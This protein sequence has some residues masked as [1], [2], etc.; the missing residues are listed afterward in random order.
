[1]ISSY[2]CTLLSL[3]LRINILSTYGFHLVTDINELATAWCRRIELNFQVVIKQCWIAPDRYKKSR[4]C[5]QPIFN[6]IHVT[7]VSVVK[8]RRPYSRRHNLQWGANHKSNETMTVPDYIVPQ[9]YSTYASIMMHRSFY[10]SAPALPPPSGLY[11]I[12]TD[13]VKH[14]NF[15]TLFIV[16]RIWGHY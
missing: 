11:H 2:V 14:I 7:A 13:F 16:E 1:M 4:N 8:V 5:M 6:K 9:D 15:S 10:V 12:F 3:F